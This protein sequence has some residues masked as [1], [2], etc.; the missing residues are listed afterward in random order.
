M[1]ISEKKLRN[2]I[3]K[4]ILSEGPIADMYTNKGHEKWRE[5]FIGSN[6]V[7]A[8]RLKPIPGNISPLTKGKGFEMAD[9]KGNWTLHQNINQPAEDIYPDLNHQLNGAAAVHYEK[10]LE[11]TAINSIE[12]IEY[13]ASQFHEIWMN[14][15]SWQKESNPQLFV[16]YEELTADEKLKDLQQVSLGIEHIYGPDS[17]EF[18]LVNQAINE[19]C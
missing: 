11:S 5:G 3:R 10:I 9:H 4:I 14:I 8:K 19:C 16:A 12:D 18:D 17:I 13:L 6:G 7:N 2:V 15:N 1:L